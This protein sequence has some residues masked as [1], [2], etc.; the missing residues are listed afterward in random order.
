M[1][2][3]ILMTAWC[4]LGDL[5]SYQ[6]K[7]PQT[8]QPSR[9]AHQLAKRLLTHPCSVPIRLMKDTCWFPFQ[10]DVPFPLQLQ[11][12]HLKSGKCQNRWNTYHNA[13][14]T[15]KLNILHKGNA[16]G[17]FKFLLIHKNLLTE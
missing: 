6:G 11:V 2:S 3:H 9:S 16:N 8:H 7:H 1:I 17:A 4:Q 10:D 12:D 14:E 13:E 5:A 15:D